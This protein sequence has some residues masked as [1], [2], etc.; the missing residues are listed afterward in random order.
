MNKKITLVSAFVL[1]SLG[2][3]AQ[4]N[5]S[6]KN[7][8]EVVVSSSKFDL[9]KE[10]SGKVIVKITAEELQKRNGQSVANVL[11]TVAGVEVNGNLGR[12]GKNLDLYIR[13]GRSQQNLIMIDGIP[14]TDASGISLQYDLRLI[15]IEQVESIEILKGAS[16]TLYGSG[17]ANG[18]INIILKKSA[19][20]EF[21]GNAYMSMGSQETIDLNN[22]YVPQDFSQGFSLNGTI[23]KIN[24]L[25]TLNSN[26]ATGM[27]EAIGTEEDKTSK[28]NS[29]VKLGYNVT[30]KLA[31]NFFANFDRLKFNFDNTFDNLNNPDTPFNV[32][33]S[34]QFRFGFA[35]KFSYKRGEFTINSA[36]NTIERN[37]N[38]FS[39]WS[40]SIDE[41]NFK[42]RSINVDLFNKYDII[43]EHLFLVVGGQFQFHEMNSKDKYDQ[44]EKEKAKFSTIDPYFTV[45]F[46]SK[47]GFNVNGGVRLNTHNVYGNHW[48]GNFNP[49]YTFNKF[50][51]KVLASISTAYIVPSLY[52]LYSPYGNLELKPEE[53]L[54]IEA[55]FET[56]LIDKKLL[57]N[58]VAFHREEKNPFGFYTDP[59]TWSSNYIN[60]EG[61]NNAKGVE[62]MISYAFNQK[63][64]LSGNYTFTQNEKQFD[65]L[66]PR[67]K[68]NAA[69]DIQATSR[70]FFNVSYLFTDKRNDAY[71]N[72]STY[73]TDKVVLS[74]YKILNATLKYE[75]VKNQFTVFA[76][77]TNILNEEFIESVGYN[78][79]GRN[80]KVGFNFLF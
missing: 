10:K 38:M 76:N 24:Y 66:I 45:V 67:H 1:T 53:D 62:S 57:L 60:N 21:S 33:T 49:S 22:N 63:I 2:L 34:E 78:T 11:N 37:Y 16:S 73:S 50:P 61:I 55:G 8:N 68:A 12:N 40:G 20:K 44:I 77:A 4:E 18:V 15:P 46:N 17:A 28:V 47:I 43:Q 29:L 69:L 41:S 54:T 75:L 58:A 51:L 13:G 6:I 65:R 32:A 64:K 52:Q 9:P 5:D 31:L 27:S 35:P 71:Y 26:E 25:A 74:A 56:N 30:D 42:S 19:K 36:F 23:N 72:A 70:A 80:F 48:I 14:V 3:F 39:S 59:V 79:R 7:L